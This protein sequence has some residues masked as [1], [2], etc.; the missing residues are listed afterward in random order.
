MYTDEPHIRVI[1]AV[2]THT[3]TNTREITKCSP[4]GA[5]RA[6]WLSRTNTEIFHPGAVT[7]RGV[8]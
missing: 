8:A 2:H 6:T 3:Y 5:T 1:V 7:E 4:Y